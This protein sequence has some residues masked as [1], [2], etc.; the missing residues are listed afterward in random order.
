M[1]IDEWPHIRA[2]IDAGR[3]SPILLAAPPESTGANVAAIKAALSASHQVVAYRY[4]LT[5]ADVTLYV[6]DPNNPTEDCATLTL[7][8][9]HPEQPLVTNNLGNF[10]AFFRGHYS[11]EDPRPV[12]G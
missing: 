6:Y 11:W 4:D 5:A 1:A 3:P 2:D 10:R 9:E 12:W 7:C 8:L